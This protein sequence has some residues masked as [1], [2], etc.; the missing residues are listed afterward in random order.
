MIIKEISTLKRNKILSNL[1]STQENF[2]EIEQNN[3][4]YLHNNTHVN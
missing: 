1:L 2:N 3:K 4:Y